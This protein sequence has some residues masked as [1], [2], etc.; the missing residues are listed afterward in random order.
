MSQVFIFKRFLTQ[1]HLTQCSGLKFCV[2]LP[3][4]EIIKIMAFLYG[5][6][7]KLLSHKK[8][9]TLLELCLSHK[10]PIS[11]SCE[12]GASCGT[13]RIIILDGAQ[14]LPAPRF[15]EAEMASDRGFKNNERLA[16]QIKVG[17]KKDLHFKLPE[18]LE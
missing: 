8:E 10:I 1:S 17:H 13:C 9:K 18:D 15:L 12:G 6:L 4:N 3:K 2:L 11:H 16:C 14:D 5:P 7:K